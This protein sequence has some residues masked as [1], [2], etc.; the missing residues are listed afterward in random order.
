MENKKRTRRSFLARDVIKLLGRSTNLTRADIAVKLKAKG[1]SVKA[2]L[3]KLVADQK[4]SCEKGAVTNA[5]TGPR[6]VNVYYLTTT[7][8]EGELRD[9]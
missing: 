7:V 6:M 3:F 4:V 8:Q 1:H 9:G 2:V 5:K